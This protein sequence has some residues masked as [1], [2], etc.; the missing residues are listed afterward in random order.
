MEET[1]PSQDDDTPDYSKR[2]QVYLLKSTKDKTELRVNMLQGDYPDPRAEP[3]HIP[4]DDDNNDPHGPHWEYP[5]Y[6]S[7]DKRGNGWTVGDLYPW[8]FIAETDAEGDGSV[9]IRFPRPAS[10]EPYVPGAENWHNIDSW[11]VWIAFQN[12]RFGFDKY[13]APVSTRTFEV[14]VYQRQ[15]WRLSYKGPPN[16]NSLM[17][18]RRT[19][20]WSGQDTG[21]HDVPVENKPDHGDL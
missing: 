17:I 14:A 20:N 9:V 2:G 1:P 21:Y 11:N 8:T 3:G 4:G 19:I 18:M 15:Y 7:Y 13:K 5:D 6:H 12:P 10:M 16:S